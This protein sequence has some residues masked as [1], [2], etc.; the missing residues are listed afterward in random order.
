MFTLVKTYY[1]AVVWGRVRGKRLGQWTLAGPRQNTGWGDA[2]V[3]HCVAHPAHV[4]HA[5]HRM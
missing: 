2:K 1:S 3:V 4:A 5:T